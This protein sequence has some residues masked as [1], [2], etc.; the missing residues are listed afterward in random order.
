MIWL[1]FMFAAHFA[2]A[3]LGNDCG[4]KLSAAETLVERLSRYQLHPDPRQTAGL[5]REVRANSLLLLTDFSAEAL[6]WSLDTVDLTDDRGHPTKWKLLKVL[7]QIPRLAPNVRADLAKHIYQRNQSLLKADDQQRGSLSIEKTFA[8]L[9][10]E[11][12][13]PIEK[14]RRSREFMQLVEQNPRAKQVLLSWVEES[15]PTLASQLRFKYRM[16]IKPIQTA[17]LNAL[18]LGVTSDV[19]LL[20]VGLDWPPTLSLSLLTVPVSFFGTMAFEK[21]L[22]RLN[23]R[24]M[25][26]LG[27]LG[28]NRRVRA[29]T[30]MPVL[31]LG[32]EVTRR[33]PVAKR[34]DSP[35]TP[36]ELEAI[37]PS[38][39]KF[40]SA[41]IQ[42]FG[43]SLLGYELKLS[44]RLMAI[45]QAS[46]ESGRAYTPRNRCDC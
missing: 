30:K 14:A 24:A 6:R 15:L 13:V 16:S 32:P 8:E 38:L 37:K 25:A 35:F 7:K 22:Q 36:A 34:W 39:K 26:A 28:Y 46:V 45:R 12:R 31:P 19:L 4:Y 1:T 21:Q 23:S 41:S 33:V 42:E 40:T 44:Y 20:H 11:R 10:L 27:R 5:I 9:E 29:L 3:T 2:F 18:A 17:L 43:H